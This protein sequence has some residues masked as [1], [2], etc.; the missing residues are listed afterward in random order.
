MP[1]TAAR[2]GIMTPRRLVARRPSEVTVSPLRTPR[3]AQHDAGL[4]RVPLVITVALFVVVGVGSAFAFTGPSSTQAALRASA[5]VSAAPTPS[6]PPVVVAVNS[7][8]RSSVA[9][10][11]PITLSVTDGTVRAM[12]ATGPD[13][14]LAGTLSPTGW[15]S[16]GRLVPSSTY[17]LM[18]TVADSR[19]TSRS[20]ARTVTTNPPDKILRVTLS[21]D[22]RTVGVGTPIIAQ[23][24]HPVSGAAARAEVLDRLKVTASPAVAGAWR[25]IN[26]YEAHYRGPE[27]WASGTKV[28]VKADLYR[29]QLPG[30]G[31]WGAEGAHT[32]DFRVGDA[33][34]S[35]VDVTA[36]TMT[37]TKNGVVLRTLPV[38]TGRDK[39]PTKGG[40]HIVLE[41]QKE[42]TFDSSTVG[43]PTASPDGY[44]EKLPYSVRISNGGAFVHANP[45][46]VRFQGVQNVSHGCVNLSLSDAAWYFS[47]A[48]RG[49]VVDI[50]N[51]AVPPVQSDPGMQDWNMPFSQWEQGNL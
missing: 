46:T 14:A 5:G 8:S 45:A 37:V 4:A 17:R 42:Q 2:A 44:F 3:S 27:Y 7:T 32:A 16:T 51:A 40:V 20:V 26:S 24:N 11:R 13:G 48:H 38:S 36:H 41:L 25:W 10:S 21:P 22:L 9:W 49:D 35:T 18:A 39:Y 6:A 50:V 31:T 15:T 47:V 12:R 23:F 1:R 43:I 33:L 28:S 19:G 30:T 34:V 29:L